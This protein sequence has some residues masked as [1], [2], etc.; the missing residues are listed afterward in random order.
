MIEGTHPSV[1]FVLVALALLL[2]H[3][4][5]MIEQEHLQLS[6]IPLT[7]PSPV[8][9]SLVNQLSPFLLQPQVL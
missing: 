2:D 4:Q 7:R 3:E 1:D 8:Q 6:T 9:R 5:R